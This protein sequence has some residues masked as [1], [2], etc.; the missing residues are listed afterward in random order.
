MFLGS[1]QEPTAATPLG[2]YLGGD[3]PERDHS[4]MND[5]SASILIIRPGCAFR[6]TTYR[7][8]DHALPLGGFGVPLNHPRFLEW[9]DAPDSARPMGGSVI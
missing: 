6:H 2:R 3:W 8:E 7:E 9:F 1:L 4:A 5:L